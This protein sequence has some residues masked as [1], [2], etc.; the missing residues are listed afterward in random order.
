MAHDAEMSVLG[1][2]VRA[3]IALARN[4]L[5][6]TDAGAIV[7]MSGGTIVTDGRGVGV[8]LQRTTGHGTETGI[9]I[10]NV[11]VTTTGTEGKEMPT[12]GEKPRKVISRRSGPEVLWDTTRAVGVGMV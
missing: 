11:T 1:T 12:G 4:A 2:T 5:E 10:V 3:M 9:A 6:T 7:E 8:V